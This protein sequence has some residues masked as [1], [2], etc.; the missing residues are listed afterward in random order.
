MLGRCIDKL[1]LEHPREQKE[2]YFEHM[3]VALCISVRL[4]MASSFVFVHAMVPGVN[5]FETIYRTSS[6][7]FL[8]AIVGTIKRTNGKESKINT[9]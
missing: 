1:F 5:L 7:K 6:T 3:G 8:N 4:L 2:T 9:I